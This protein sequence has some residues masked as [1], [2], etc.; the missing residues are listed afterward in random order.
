MGGLIAKPC[1]N[2]FL[3]EAWLV[4]RKMAHINQS[5]GHLQWLHWRFDVAELPRE[6]VSLRQ[7]R[8]TPRPSS[9]EAVPSKGRANCKQGN[10][11]ATMQM[12]SDLPSLPAGAA[13]REPRA[14]SAPPATTTG[15]GGQSRR[16]KP[17]LDRGVAPV[18]G[19]VMGGRYGPAKGMYW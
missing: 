15:G 5:L 3:E 11:T 7:T 14:R 1:M 18:E 9:N 6:H 16:S 2:T 13:A 17:P 10:K 19:P 4:A 12:L 8:C